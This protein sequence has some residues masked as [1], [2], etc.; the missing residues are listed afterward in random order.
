[1]LA[2]GFNHRI[3]TICPSLSP[4]D[5]HG[6]CVQVAQE[7]G[8]RAGVSGKRGRR[9]ACQRF[10]GVFHVHLA[11]WESPGESIPFLAVPGEAECP[12]LP[13]VSV[14]SDSQEFRDGQA[15]CPEPA[16]LRETRSEVTGTR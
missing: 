5:L 14:G 12:R 10:G 15:G 1:M 8:D 7:P 16:W 9:T 6:L 13:S 4:E 11:A 2:P 3:K